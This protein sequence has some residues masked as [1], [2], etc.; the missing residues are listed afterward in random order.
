MEKP[1]V[2]GFDGSDFSFA[3]LQKGL[4]LARKIGLPVRILRAWTV[5]TAP[6][7]TSWVPGYVP[8]V[9][10]FEAAVMEKFKADIAEI[11]AEFPDVKITLETPHGAAGRSLINASDEASLLIVGT[12]GIGGFAGL[13]IGS[14][15]DQCV[16]HA[17]CDVMVVRKPTGNQ[18]PGRAVELDKDW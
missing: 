7:P 15:S 11:I 17:N 4:I 12:R 1:I 5:S 9:E 10:D 16:E 2:I 6:R 8:P 18:M 13:L 3:A 14:V